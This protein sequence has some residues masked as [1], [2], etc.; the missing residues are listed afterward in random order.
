MANET[1][2]SHNCHNLRQKLTSTAFQVYNGEG[3]LLILFSLMVRAFQTTELKLKLGGNIRNL[4]LFR[5]MKD[6]VFQC[7]QAYWFYNTRGDYGQN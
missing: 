2:V 7:H 5:T 3:Y 4:K 6:N 1:D